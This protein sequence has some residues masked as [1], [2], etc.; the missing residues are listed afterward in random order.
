MRDGLRLNAAITPTLTIQDMSGSV[1]TSFVD[2][3]TYI[4][5]LSDVGNDTDP[6]TSG[7]AVMTFDVSQALLDA[8][9]PDGI[10]K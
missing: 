10:I 6:S 8:G 4:Y 2:G 1:S 5:D 3:V 7:A 9:E